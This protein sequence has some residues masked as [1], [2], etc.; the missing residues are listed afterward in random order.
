MLSDLLR[1][2]IN[3]LPGVPDDIMG[4]LPWDITGSLPEIILRMIQ[5][6]NDQYRIT[7][8]VAIHHSAVVDR[9]AVIKGPAI[10][11][12]D[13]FVGMNVLLRGGIF[14]GSASKIGPGCEIK[15]SI[16]GSRTRVAH[17]NFIG[18]SIIGNDVNFEGGSIVA[19]HYNERTRKNIFVKYQGKILDTGVDKFGAL[20]GD[21][22]RIGANAVLSPGTMLPM[23]FIVKRL[24]L[25]EQT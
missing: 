23:G 1:N 7:A 10:I 21:D 13:C 15:T 24:E 19:N 18:D 22:C 6:L 11:S 17:F 5:D 2:Y 8:D 3:A 4:L 16:I 25:V 20:V 12:D 9:Q 14:L